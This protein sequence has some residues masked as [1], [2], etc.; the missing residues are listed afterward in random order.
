MSDYI[1]EQQFLDYYKSPAPTGDGTLAGCITAASRS[2]DAF[3]GRNFYI[4]NTTR[5]FSGYV[6]EIASYWLLPIDDLANTTGL[7]VHTDSNGAGT[8][9]NTITLN[10][11]FV[12][13]PVNQEQG[14]ILGWPYSM[15]RSLQP[16]V[17][18][19]RYYAWQP[20][21]VKILGNWGWAAVPYPVQQAC[22]ILTAQYVKMADAPLGVAGFGSYGDVRVRDIPQVATLLDPYRHDKSFGIA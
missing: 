19:V 21:T 22:K 1:T 4:T 20:H 13:E 3:C 8:Y 14:G 7:A 11:D 6:G 5:Y 9:A 16:L 10:T 17:F 15:M 2:I 18:P 12:L